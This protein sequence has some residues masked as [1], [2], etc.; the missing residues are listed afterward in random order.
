MRTPLRLANLIFNQPQLVS[1]AMMS[2]AVHWANQAMHLNIVNVQVQHGAVEME[3]TG[4]NLGDRKAEK[5]PPPSDTGIGVI[6]IH[7]LLVSRMAHMDPCES[8][9]SYE[10]IRSRLHQALADPVIEHIILDIDSPGGS[11]TGAFELADDIYAART[12]KPITAIAHFSAYSAAYLLASAASEVVV[13]RTSGIGSIGVI[14]KH[15]DLSKHHEQQGVKLTAVYAGSHKN[16]LTPYEPIN[17][18]S[19]QLLNDMVQEHY[20]QLTGA[21][22]RY[23]DMTTQAVKATEAGVFCG[24]RSI[25]CKLADR[26]EMPHEAMSRVAVQTQQQRTHATAQPRRI[27]ACATAI[28]MQNQL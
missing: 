12:I 11:A 3:S 21:V 4:I 22:A 8:M 28:A 27:A 15:L 24:Q 13:S 17:D 25:D 6:P 26:L 9:T 19:L 23:R 1:D 20:A 18:Q 2:L 16:D 10:S 7:G 5:Q 14:A